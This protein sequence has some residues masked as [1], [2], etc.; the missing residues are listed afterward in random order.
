MNQWIYTEYINIYTQYLGYFATIQVLLISASSFSIIKAAEK[1]KNWVPIYF[2][3]GSFTFS[4]INVFLIFTIYD[5]IRTMLLL[6][7]DKCEVFNKK[8]VCDVNIQQHS[9]TLKFAITLSIIPLISLI[10]GYILQHREK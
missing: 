1:I 9:C 3:I 5:G 8:L 6:M 10:I 7:S 4:I 2:Y